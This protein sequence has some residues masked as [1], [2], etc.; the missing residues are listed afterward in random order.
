MGIRIYNGIKFVSTD[1]HDVFSQI[2]SFRPTIAD[3]TK[4]GVGHYLAH[5]LATMIDTEVANGTELG[6]NYL[7]K[8]TNQFSESV[9]EMKKNGRRNPIID[10]EFK[11]EI[12]P[13]NGEFYGMVFTEKGE[14][15]KEMIAQGWATDFWYW[16][17]TDHDEDIS[18]EDWDERGKLWDAI[19][20]P[21][22]VPSQH[23]VE[24]DLTYQILWPDWEWIEP[25]FPTFDF[26][27]SQVSESRAAHAHMR[28]IIKKDEAETDNSHYMAAFTASRKWLKT[29]DGKAA[30]AAMADTVRPL[31]PPVLTRFVCDGWSK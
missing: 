24:A 5:R 21:D 14:W 6:G 26:R 16:D 2:Q 8:V 19:L 18:E 4:K 28:E 20:G 30:V 7:S 10:F 1:F 13:H 15:K 11:I 22:Y 25:N 12:F 31:L 27:L 29:D 23:G 17:N 3:L 9:D